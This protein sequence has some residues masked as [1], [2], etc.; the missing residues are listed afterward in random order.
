MLEARCG[1]GDR[2]FAST[3]APRIHH[4]GAKKEGVG[5]VDEMIDLLEEVVGVVGCG[6][7][8][9]G[10]S[11]CGVGGGSGRWRRRGILGG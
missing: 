9:V 10:G 7:G 5:R 11:G 4:R 2:D 3:L 8:D 1:E 6:A